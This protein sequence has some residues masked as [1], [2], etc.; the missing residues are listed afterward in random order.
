M[1]NLELRKI[2]SLKRIMNLGTNLE[3]RY[4]PNIP[5]N[6]SFLAFELLNWFNKNT[7]N[8]LRLSK[9]HS[10]TFFNTFKKCILMRSLR[11]S[12]ICI[13][14][15]SLRLWKCIL[16]FRVEIWRE[17]QI[18]EIWFQN[19]LISKLD[20]LGVSGESRSSKLVINYWACMSKHIVVSKSTQSFEVLNTTCWN[21]GVGINRIGVDKQN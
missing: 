14:T 5:I 20:E 11:L 10:H 8:L 18:F 1:E 15:H 21:K 17:H 13:L 2:L 7:T 3:T 16:T 19:Q 12:K 6:L 4:H 9:M